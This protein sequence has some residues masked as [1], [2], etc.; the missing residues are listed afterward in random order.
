MSRLAKILAAGSEGLVFLSHASAKAGFR[1][2]DDRQLMAEVTKLR[3]QGCY[4]AA[5]LTLFQAQERLFARPAQDPIARLF[6]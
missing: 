1:A 2:P 6:A 5:L 4:D 3:N